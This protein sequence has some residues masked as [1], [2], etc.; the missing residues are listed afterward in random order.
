[1]KPT[2]TADNKDIKFLSTPQ[3]L[4]IP[5]TVY[6]RNGDG[7]PLLM[8][9]GL[10]SHSGWFTESASFIA[11]LG[12][13]VY[14]IDRYGSGLSKAPKGGFRSLKDSIEDIDIV[15]RY[16]SE[17]HKKKMVHILGHCYGAMLAA[18]YACVHNYKIKSLILPT[19]AIFTKSDITPL[20]KLKII[21]SKISGSD[22]MI[23]IP[24]SAE[25]MSDIDEYVS[26]IKNDALS[27]HDASSRFFF[28]VTWMRKFI[29][30]NSVNITA[31]VFMAF[32]GKDPICQNNKNKRFFDSL[33]SE[34]KELKVY[35]SARHILE[36][37]CEKDNFFKDIAIWFDSFNRVLILVLT[38]F[39]VCV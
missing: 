29:L 10:Q 8:L 39:S 26:F 37:S 28:E 34:K 5:V 25:M 17:L 4:K 16:A 15:A 1:M 14:A 12:I 13:P 27:L 36:F 3:G 38:I 23:P 18:A 31:P 35:N 6:G 30:K 22:V 21:W 19:P 32:A 20:D 9:H 2:T 11:S 7:V 24:L 33:R